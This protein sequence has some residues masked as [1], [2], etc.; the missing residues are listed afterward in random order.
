MTFGNVFYSVNANTKVA[1][2][3]SHWHTEYKR[4]ADGNSM[5]FQWSLLYSF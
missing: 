1:F 5:R 3:V 2:E 4:L